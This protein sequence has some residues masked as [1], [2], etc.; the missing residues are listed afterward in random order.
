MFINYPLSIVIAKSSTLLYNIT[1]TIAWDFRKKG[2]SMDLQL[3]LWNIHNWLDEKETE[4]FYTLEDELPLFTGIRFRSPEVDENSYAV[5]SDVPDNSQYRSILAFKNGRIYF[6]FLSAAD[7]M[8][9]LN[10]ILSTYKKR[11]KDLMQA[12][13]RHCDLKEILSIASSLLPVPLAIIRNMQ[14]EAQTSDVFCSSKDLTIDLSNPAAVSKW[15]DVFK[16]AGSSGPPV[17]LETGSLGRI[18]LDR[19]PFRHHQVFLAAREKDRPFTQ[20]DLVLFSRIRTAVSIHLRSREKETGG[21][22][23]YSSNY[24]FTSLIEGTAPSQESL[25]PAIKKLN[26]KAEDSFVVYTIQL[27]DTE[28]RIYPE[29]LYYLLR[30]QF[31]SGYTLIYQDRVF[32]F[33]NTAMLSEIPDETYFSG[34]FP[35]GLVYIGQSNINSGISHLQVL[36][37]QAEQALLM[38]KQTRRFF[39]SALSISTQTVLKQFYSDSELQAMVHPAV[40]L[41]NE[42]DKSGTAGFGYLNTLE[43]FLNSGT[44][45]SAASRKLRLHRNTF[46]NRIERIKELTGLSLTDPEELE[47][48]LLSLI[49]YN[50]YTT[51]SGR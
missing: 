45:I 48:L 8:N 17:I 7:A 18:M 25:V 51:E 20:A 4:H 6:R 24:A 34:L 43:A 41:L 38:A 35:D 11:L 46:I 39:V 27:A 40:I 32:L 3:S 50:R 9:L 33:L 30:S 23:Y 47:A 29:P 21:R 42:L 19:I 44:N 16:R 49:I 12:N 13:L 1:E 15:Y 5:L 31:Q 14:I 10:K 26:W 2:P 37:R 36:I 28:L 22:F